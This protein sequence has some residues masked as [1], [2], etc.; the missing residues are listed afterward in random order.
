MYGL[1]GGSTS[2]GPATILGCLLVVICAAMAFS[3]LF[4]MLWHT[5]GVIF[6]GK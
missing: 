1:P 2:E 4:A 5:A 6:N 3:C